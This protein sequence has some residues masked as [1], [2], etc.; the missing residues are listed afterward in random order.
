MVAVLLTAIAAMLAR[1]VANWR[2]AQHRARAERERFRALRAERD[3]AV[4]RA[5]IAAELHDSVGH[6]LTAIIALSEELAGGVDPEVDEALGG[7]N[8]VARECLEQTRR[9]VR[10]L[11][12]DAGQAYLWLRAHPGGAHQRGAAR[13]RAIAGAGTLGQRRAGGDGDGSQR[14]RLG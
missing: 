11:A 5:G 14:R 2:A 4:S 10:A 9:A 13:P 8:E 1:S 3:R 6:G 7:I 12:D